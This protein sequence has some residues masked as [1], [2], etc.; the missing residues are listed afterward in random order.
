MLAIFF[1]LLLKE[2]QKLCE[3][4]RR[5]PPAPGL[6]VKAR[7]LYEYPRADARPEEGER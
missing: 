6:F 1:S 5:F 7:A 3:A 4:A 2:S